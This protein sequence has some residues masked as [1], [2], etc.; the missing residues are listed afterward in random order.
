[1]N[2]ANYKNTFIILNSETLYYLID[3]NKKKKLLR[4]FCKLLDFPNSVP[5]KIKPLL[6]KLTSLFFVVIIIIVNP[7]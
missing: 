4:T 3:I 7:K 6:I 2:R 1:M 5:R